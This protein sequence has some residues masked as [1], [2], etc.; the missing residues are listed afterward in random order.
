M[1]PFFSTCIYAD[2][3]RRKEDASVADNLTKGSKAQILELARDLKIGE[4]IIASITPSI[5]GQWHVKLELAMSLFDAV[6]KIICDNYR[7]RGD[8]NI[9]LLGDIMPAK[10]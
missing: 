3:V 2:H 7:I 6:P 5:Y 1:F 10:S 4:Q 8:I 9:L